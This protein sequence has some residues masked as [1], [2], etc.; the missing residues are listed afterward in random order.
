MDT[1][2]NRDPSSSFYYPRQRI[3]Q[4]LAKAAQYPLAVICAGAGYG[5]TS[6]VYDFTQ[7]SEA[8]VGW[9]ELTKSDNI[10][11]RFWEN[12]ANS[13]TQV[14]PD[15]AE[16]I[17][18]LGFPDS[19][20]KINR[21]LSI[22]KTHL[23]KKIHIQV[24]DNF[25]FIEDPAVMYFVE[26]CIGELP[27]GSSLFFI[28]RSMSNINIANLVSKGHMF[29]IGENE[30]RFTEAE[31]A[32][33]FKQEGI[34]P[35][36]EELHEIYED[37]GGWAF[38]LNLIARSYKKAPSY[39]GFLRNAMKTNIFVLMEAE[40]FNGTSG[41]LQNFLIRLSLIEH[42]SVELVGLLAGGDEKL[43]SEFERQNTYVRLDVYTNAYLIQHFF[44][45]FLREKQSLL[46]ER[47]KS[48]TYK[49]AADWNNANGIRIDAISYYEKIGDYESIV[50]IFFGLQ[51]NIPY[52]I[53]RYTTEIF[54]R[55]PEEAFDRVPLLSAI[56]IRSVMRL[57]LLQKAATLIEH[58]E[59]KYSRLSE[60]SLFRNHTLA[61][62]YYC[63]GIMRT[64]MCT[65]DDCYDFDLYYE[66]MDACLTRTPLEQKMMPGYPV[67]QWI[68]LVGS[69]RKGAQQEYIDALSRA[70]IHVSHCMY[71]TMTGMTDLARGELFYHQGNIADAEPLIVGGMERAR[72]R[73]QLELVH[74]GLDYLLRMAVY[75]GNF[76]KAEQAV[77][78]MRALVSESSYSDRFILYDL[79]VGWYY[80]YLEMPEL[81]PDWLKD[82]FAAFGHMYGAENFGN[83][84]KAQYYYFTRNYSP[85][86]AY[87]RE[88]R[89]RESILY[90]RV[91]TLA[92]EAC[93]YSKIKDRRQAFAALKEAYD[94]AESSGIT[95]PFVNLG[96]DMR[97]LCAAALKEPGFGIPED[98]L[99]MIRSKSSSYA[100]RQSHVIVEYKRAY[101]IR[102]GV[103]VTKREIDIITDISHGLSHTEIAVSRGLSVN[104]VKTVISTIHKKLNTENLADLIRVS[105]E[106]KL[107]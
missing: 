87:L 17:K 12:Y 39:N 71:G 65:A 36:Q 89:Q 5:K 13:A 49:I 83:R 2:A 99:E 9:T 85:L 3:N 46:T 76:V 21:F 44:L 56:R 100:K 66:K 53:A 29:D 80:I 70:E 94:A 15:Y 93:V 24:F 25:H 88:Q 75:Q 67:G 26:S 20:D 4:L 57:G 23:E 78:D 104:T 22:V 59:K 61:G 74:A 47:E 35:R 28:T 8:V 63:R 60:D 43:I 96:K 45:E 18:A 95:M 6:A 19:D 27:R 69:T 107:I 72:R 106:N 68:S 91:E 33:Y 10:G 77:N 31:L 42:L 79:S 16:A 102:E 62:L 52:D 41:R 50:K 64:M 86:I 101:N 51:T 7:E 38:A 82:R 81:I 92:M 54:D 48:E 97:T 37:T 1:V 14:S 90:G 11:V 40:F 58:Y 34:A 84:V 30:L 55:A 103:A 98:W 32:G 105:I 73:G